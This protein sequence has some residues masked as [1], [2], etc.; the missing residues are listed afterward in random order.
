MTDG[1]PIDDG[2][3]GGFPWQ[4]LLDVEKQEAGRY[5]DVVNTTVF[6]AIDGAP[7]RVLE[8]GCAGGALGAELKRRFPQASVVGVEPA[9]AAA[10]LAATR[11]DRVIR[12]RLEEIDYAAEGLAP[13]TFDTIIAA[14]VLEHVFN[15]WQALVRMK[16][17]LAPGGQLVASIPNVRNAMLVA[18][19]AVNGRWEYRDRGLLD[20][21]HLRFFTLEEIRRL[22]AQTGYRF[23]AHA[24]RLSPPLKGVYEKNRDKARVT[25]QLGRLTLADLTPPELLEL[26]TEQF[27]VR[28]RPLP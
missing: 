18:A 22:F 16:P 9:E 2:S 27:C 15:P 6:E 25:L 24:A 4:T 1:H 17:L 21:T 26:C 14:D 20:I 7:R 28:A 3:R 10:D 19:L 13:G 5:P 8:L 12:A 23:E 11:L